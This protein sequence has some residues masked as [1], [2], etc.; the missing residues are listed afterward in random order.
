[1]VLQEIINY[2]L[3]HA[4]RHVVEVVKVSG[5][6]SGENHIRS[7]KQSFQTTSCAVFPLG[8]FSCLVGFAGN[9]F[10]NNLAGGFLLLFERNFI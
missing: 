4:A 10:E 6:V 2:P 3:S 1:M 8:L 9:G 5:K 7:H